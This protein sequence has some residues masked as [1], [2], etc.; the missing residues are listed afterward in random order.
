MYVKLSDLCWNIL[1]MLSHIILLDSENIRDQLPE[2]TSK[3]Q[4]RYAIKRLEE[5]RLVEVAPTLGTM[6]M[7]S[8]RLSMAQDVDM[9]V[10]S[11][12]IKDRIY[13]FITNPLPIPA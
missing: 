5:L 1:E 7:K 2:E 9:T 13:N 12:K 8:Y 10:F 11:D 3:E 6:N 4:Y